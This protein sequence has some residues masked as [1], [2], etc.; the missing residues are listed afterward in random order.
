M[1]FKGKKKD[2]SVPGNYTD[3]DVREVGKWLE[4][5]DLGRYRDAFFYNEIDGE[6]L[7]DIDEDDLI[8]IP[9]ERLGHRKKI[10]RRLATLRGTTAS[11]CSSDHG[12]EDSQS[13]ASVASSATSVAS[14]A[15]TKIRIKCTYKEEVRTFFFTPNEDF[16]GFMGKIK[17]EFGKSLSAKYMDEDGDMIVIRNDADVG[18]VIVTARTERVK[19][20]LYASRKKEKKSRLSG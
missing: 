4:S 13:S 10:M 6:M 12:S 14:S 17:K 16:E 15:S 8:A 7:A 19:L 18:E 2:T 3:W 11:S 9:I 5:F 1:N 20:I